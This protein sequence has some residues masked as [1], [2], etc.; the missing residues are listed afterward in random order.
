MVFIRRPYLVVTVL[1]KLNP[2]SPVEKD[3]PGMWSLVSGT[4]QLLPAGLHHCGDD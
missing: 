2:I 3:P 4:G 1:G